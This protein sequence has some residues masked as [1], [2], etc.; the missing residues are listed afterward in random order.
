MNRIEG[1]RSDR[2]DNS[3]KKGRRIL[4]AEP[5]SANTKPA[6]KLPEDRNEITDLDSGALCITSW[7]HATSETSE[8]KAGFTLQISSRYAASIIAIRFDEFDRR[9]SKRPTIR[10]G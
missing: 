2:G 5:S 8:L 7:M 1:R 3:L 10:L 6:Q 9:S 4:V